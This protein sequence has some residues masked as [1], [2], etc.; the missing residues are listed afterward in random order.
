MDP[1]FINLPLLVESSSS[2]VLGYAQRLLEE[3]CSD[4]PAGADQQS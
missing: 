3:G 1:L 2:S 4:S